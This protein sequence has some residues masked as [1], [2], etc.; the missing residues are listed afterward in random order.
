[1]NTL[2]CMC[3]SQYQRRGL[4]NGITRLKNHKFCNLILSGAMPVFPF[5]PAFPCSISR[6]KHFGGQEIPAHLFSWT[7]VPPVL[8][9]SFNLRVSEHDLV[10][11]MLG[12]GFQME[13][14]LKHLE[15]T[16]LGSEAYFLIVL[17]SLVECLLPEERR[18]E[19]IQ[20][21]QGIPTTEG[22][23]EVP[24]QSLNDSCTNERVS[25]SR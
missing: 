25:S 21:R 2:A 19:M 16:S 5:L 18:K 11:L 9:V 24:G 20:V 23:K 12:L 8:T 14:F 10:V 1:M 3:V 15:I 17:C 22:S 6:D 7:C 13:K 4:K